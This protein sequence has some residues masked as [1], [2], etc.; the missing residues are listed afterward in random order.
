MDM[1]NLSYAVV[2]LHYIAKTIEEQIGQGAPSED[3][4]K[5]ADRLNE[6]LQAPR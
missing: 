5:A 6:L 4:R 2:N 3:I 1:T